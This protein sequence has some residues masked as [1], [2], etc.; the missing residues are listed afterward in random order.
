[1]T[2]I[3]TILFLL[4]ALGAMYLIRNQIVWRVRSKAVDAIYAGDDYI[5]ESRKYLHQSS[6]S[7][8]YGW[9]WMMLDLTKWTFE[10]F[11][12]ELASRKER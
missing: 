4:W 7:Q 8:P 2:I 1:M 6:W 10:D 5:A 3:F 9:D 11:F 12:P